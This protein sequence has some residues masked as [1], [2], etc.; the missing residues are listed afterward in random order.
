MKG[1][2]LDKVRFGKVEFL[3][4][5]N[6]VQLFFDVAGAYYSTKAKIVKEDGLMSWLIE[7][8]KNI[9]NK[10]LELE[11]DYGL[12]CKLSVLLDVEASYYYIRGYL[13]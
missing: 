13:S 12:Y 7:T 3:P 4:S 2:I 5:E 11:L 10:E 1:I 6:V 9:H 8:P